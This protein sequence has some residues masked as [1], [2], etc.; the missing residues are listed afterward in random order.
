MTQKSF[1]RGLTGVAVLTAV[2]VWAVSTGGA[3]SQGAQQDQIQKGKIFQETYPL[4][5]EAD[6]YC[7]FGAQDGPLPKLMVSGAERQEERILFGDGD[8]VYLNGGEKQGVAKDQVYLFLDVK[9]DIN[10]SSPRTGKN[11]G[12]LVQKAGRGRVISTEDDKSVLRIEKSCSP[13]FV[14]NYVVPFVEGKTVIGKDSGFVPYSREKQGTAKGS[15][16][17]LGGELNQIGSGNWA[18]ID[19]GSQDG[20]EPGNQLTVSTILGGKLPRHAI[21]NAVVIGAEA[22]TA[23]IKILAAGDA[24]RLG[25]QVE[26][27]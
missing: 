25:D 19:L 4:I 5:T 7:S 18:I 23:T 10:I 9:S 13:V 3:Q 12:H 15:V 8:I 21:G 27:K 20:L 6:L 1:I 24:I 11:Y 22:R 26:T 17:F 2:L 14:G 16:I